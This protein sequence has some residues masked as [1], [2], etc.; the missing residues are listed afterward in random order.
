MIS[1]KEISVIIKK[2]EAI[3]DECYENLEKCWDELTDALTEDFNITRKFLLKDC[4]A[5]E[6]SMVSEVYDDIVLKT[7]SKEYI[8]LLYKSIKRFPEED[9]KYNLKDNLDLAVSSQ[10]REKKNL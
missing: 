2:L 9:K 4:K 8:D 6:V 3:D 1:S 7:Q 10:L 5:N